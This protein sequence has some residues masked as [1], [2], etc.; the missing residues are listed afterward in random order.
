MDPY[1]INFS[2]IQ[3]DDLG[4][5]GGKGL[6]LGKLIKVL[7]VNVPNG[8][9]ITTDAFIE[10]IRENK[11]I[12]S[13]LH[14]LAEFK[15][16]N[17]EEIS[18]I[19][20]QLRRE[21]ESITIPPNIEN[22]ILNELLKY[23]SDEF[24]AVRSSA[25]AE[26]LP[27]ASFAGQQDTFLN[28]T[29]RN[30]ILQAIKKCWASVYSERAIFYRIE[31]GFE[32]DLVMLAV[33]IQ[34]M[35][36]SEV[37]GIMF[38][39]DPLTSDRST[40]SIDA[41]FGLGEAM[42]SGVTNPDIYKVKDGVIISKAIGKQ[43]TIIDALKNGGTISREISKDKQSNQVLS[44][45]SILEL[46]DVGRKIEKYFKYPQD[47]EWCY[48]KG[49]FYIV[50][51]RAITT[52]FPIPDAMG[53]EKPRVYFSTGHT[54]MMTDAIKPLGMSFFEMISEIKLTR[55]GGR[56]YADAT[57]DLSS[58]IGRKRLIMATG[59]QD[60]L[61]QKAI[62]NLISD[63]E[64]KTSLPKGK[65]NI[66]GGIFNIG[67]ILETIRIRKN[68]DS[69]IIEEIIEDLEKQLK[70]LEEDL[71][72]LSDIDALN[73]I[74]N[75]KKEL[76]AAAYHP[77]MLGAIIAA[78][79]ANESINKNAERWLGEKN[80]ADK[81]SKS[82][83]HN[84]T[85]EM[86]LTLCD[87][88]DKIRDYPEII[89]YLSEEPNDDDFFINMRE[90]NGG[91]EIESEFNHFFVK[92]GMRCPGEIDITKYRFE[93]RPTQLIPIILSNIRILRRGEHL[94]RFHSGEIEAFEK[95]KEVLKLLKNLP[96]GNKK[97]KKMK[98]DI[99]ILRNFLGCR[100]YPKYY[101]VRRYQLYKS[102]IFKI[103]DNLLDNG[104]IHDKEDIFY[105]YFDELHK[106]V[107]TGIV[108]YE[109]INKRKNEFTHFEK[110]T[111]PR[112]ITSEGHVPQ[113]SV[114]SKDTPENS[115]TGIPVSS[116]VIEGR[117]R[118]I[119]SVEEADLEEGDI[120]VTRFTDPSWTSLFSSIK[121]L[122]T[123]VG[124]FTTHGAVV[125]RE[126]G[127]PCVVGVENATKI[128]RDGQIVR[129]NGSEG[130]VEML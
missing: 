9:C 46:Y 76:L 39:A 45:E 32:H 92:Y 127:L 107:E 10:V 29:G 104:I 70:S 47:I 15:K 5:V 61:I 105:L 13:L 93:E 33:V 85:T 24:F 59:K 44:D 79:F 109:I 121:G 117:A 56:L 19:S 52:L 36:F 98:S 114:S 110:L 42:V 84:V 37:S 26:D 27:T 54:Q 28:V 95:E 22:A 113:V 60:L 66:K 17:R 58:A 21:I 18:K 74:R 124:G 88:S 94:E 120:L 82:L 125:A 20:L 73:F 34:K 40:M 72:S 12:Q 16:E 111:P 43:E 101:I 71:S 64:F 91:E 4:R 14:V 62:I 99:S 112:V 96:G 50:Q 123:E 68:N 2:K 41:G 80:F 11:Y 122:V 38:T 126:Y 53:L 100:E 118:V 128:I 3:S 86:G 129:I 97:A 65:R 31:Q 102:V 1:I 63:A 89:K 67:S 115:L 57:H 25:T 35:V 103:A 7:G 8:F 55:V 119:L 87:L 130:Y 77:K 23:E 69:K 48:Q 75:D 30:E 116:G 6:N 81:I 90:L 108:D 49:K 51:S 83:K 106:T 78:I